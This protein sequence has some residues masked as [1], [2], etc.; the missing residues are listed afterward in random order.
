MGKHTFCVIY[1]K[2]CMPLTQEVLKISE[3]PFLFWFLTNVWFG[4][5][6][7]KALFGPVTKILGSHSGSQR[8]LCIGVKFNNSI[9]HGAALRSQYLRDWTILG[10]KNENS[11]RNVS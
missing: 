10:V 1:S 6:I 5:L 4:I 11:T 7:F 2:I 8:K 3:Y 9:E